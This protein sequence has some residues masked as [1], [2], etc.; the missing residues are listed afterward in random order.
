MSYQTYTTE[1]IVCGSYASN[2]SD[3]SFLLFT[4][5]AGML[6]ATAR[7]VREEKSKQRHAL[8]DF[9]RIRVSLVK[10]KSGW[11]IGSVESLGNPFMESAT[12]SA[13]VALAQ[14]IKLLRRYVHG[15]GVLSNV[16]SDTIE[17]LALIESDSIDQD[18]LL[19]VFHVRLLAH[20]GY[21]INIKQL[22]DLVNHRS[23]EYALSQ[24]S[25]AYDFAIERAIESGSEASH[26]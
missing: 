21:S 3:K 4:R 23:I 16:F 1:A 13:R 12:K 11:R 9:S 18:I 2:T 7:S 5:D 26:L 20:L 8:Q 14:L 17:T 19:S 6:F 22:G 25:E 15:E 24:Y 10:G